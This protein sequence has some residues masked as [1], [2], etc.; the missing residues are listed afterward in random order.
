MSAVL[1]YITTK[2]HEE[3]SRLADSLLQERLIACANIFPTMESRYWWNGKIEHA[4]ESVLICKTD[5][6]NTELVT[7]RI[8]E[9]HS[10]E[11]PC[12]LALP[13]HVGNTDYLTWIEQ[14]SMA[15]DSGRAG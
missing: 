8:V 4:Q 12:V 15:W 13:I 7:A 1:L 10:Y 2:D 9:L 14:E 3:A 5:S 11:T 6:R